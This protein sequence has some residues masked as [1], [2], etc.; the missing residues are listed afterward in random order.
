MRGG[1]GLRDRIGHSAQ[2]RVRKR[3]AVRGGNVDKTAGEIGVVCRE[4]CIDLRPE[5]GLHRREVGA[6][7]IRHPARHEALS[8]A[9][10][11]I[12]GAGHRPP[13]EAVE[14]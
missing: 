7:R 1:I 11:V 10:S 5:L 14:L 9:H 8:V 4:R 12:C 3:N 13:A 2:Q 6:L